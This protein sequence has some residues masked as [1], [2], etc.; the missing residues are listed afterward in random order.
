[1]SDIGS[2]KVGSVQGKESEDTDDSKQNLIEV[3]DA[4]DPK[5][6]NRRSHTYQYQ[7]QRPLTSDSVGV[8][9]LEKV[10][11]DQKQKDVI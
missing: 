1:M 10:D 8:D 6:Q 2:N 11:I 5:A 3:E 9:T 7:I 4:Y